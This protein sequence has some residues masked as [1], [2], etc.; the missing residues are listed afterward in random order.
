[1]RPQN[2][3]MFVDDEEAVLAG[4]DRLLSDRGLEVTTARDGASAIAELQ[5]NPVNVVVSDLRM[6]DV[7]GLELLEWMH[8][9]Q[10]GTPFILMTGY[11]DDDVERRARELVAVDYL[12]K[13]V[14]PGTLGAA[15]D[16]ALRMGLLPAAS[17]E[18]LMAP[19]LATVA[20]EVQPVAEEAETVAAKS[21]GVLGTIGSLIAAPLVGLAFVIFLPLI[22][23]GALIMV[24]G[25]IVRDKIWPTP[26]TGVGGAGDGT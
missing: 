3:V 14:A 16:A 23:F 1:M 8:D 22:G 9:E 4:W 5:K 12:A 11:G 15:I 25:E 20:Q 21:L 24:L 10:P 6:P 18:A 26:A 19:P 7:N 2:R 17:A 13:P